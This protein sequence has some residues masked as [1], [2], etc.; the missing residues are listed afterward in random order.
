MQKNIK[1]R[2]NN[3]LSLDIDIFFPTSASD[4]ALHPSSDVLASFLT[5]ILSDQKAG[6]TMDSDTPFSRHNGW[7]DNG[8]VSATEC[9]QESAIANGLT[10]AVFSRKTAYIHLLICLHIVICSLLV[11][12]VTLVH[13]L[14]MK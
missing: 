11:E 12:Q 7:W 4:L 5:T 3:Y 10:Q 14:A 1:G 8:A 9:L 13:G 2:Q 6:G